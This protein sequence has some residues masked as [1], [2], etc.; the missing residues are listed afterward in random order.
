MTGATI[1]VPACCFCDELSGGHENQYKAIYG[2]EAP[3]R[4]LWRTTNFAVVP[5]LG[6]L[7]QD[8]LLVIP[9]SH[10]TS[11]R[12]LG[13]SARQELASTVGQLRACLEDG[14]RRTVIF[15]HGNPVGATSGGCGIVHAHLHVVPIK[16]QVSGPPKKP[17][18]SWRKLNGLMPYESLEAATAGD[19]P[20]L[21]FCGQDAESWVAIVDGVESQFFRRWLVAEL[22]LGSWDWR[23][24]GIEEAVLDSIRRLSK[25]GASALP[26]G[27]RL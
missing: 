1:T 2:R 4:L 15:E 20:Y 25:S 21:Y 14:A 26:R 9:F 17:G 11:I 6:A 13:V 12:E 5:S 18:I 22:E 16:R 23:E 19:K 7:V 10:V 8:Y 3:S 27:T 24:A